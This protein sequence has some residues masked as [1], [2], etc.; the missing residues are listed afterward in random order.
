M[1]ARKSLWTPNT[2]YRVVTEEGAEAGRGKDLD[3]LKEPL[4]PTFEQA[5]A[6]IRFFDIR[7]AVQAIQMNDGTTVNVS[8]AFHLDQKLIGGKKNA[9]QSMGKFNFTLSAIQSHP[10]EVTT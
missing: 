1:L 4:R 7:I 3:A 8:K 5:M 2:R 9:T 10:L 6:G